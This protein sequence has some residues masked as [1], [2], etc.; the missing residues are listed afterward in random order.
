[1]VEND[2]GFFIIYRV[3]SIYRVGLNRIGFTPKM[4][5]GNCVMIYIDSPQKHKVHTVTETGC[6][7]SE[8]K[9]VARHSAEPRDLRLQKEVENKRRN[10]PVYHVTRVKTFDFSS[11]ERDSCL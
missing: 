11:R 10:L 5:S 7:C 6:I 1:M 2:S 4:S 3:F 9:T 8:E